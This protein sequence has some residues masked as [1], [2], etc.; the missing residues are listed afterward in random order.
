MEAATQEE[1]QKEAFLG[2]KSER[3]RKAEESEKAAFKG[4]AG[5]TQA[6]LAQQSKGSF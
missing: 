3:R 2:L 4:A 1:L 6:S 5:T